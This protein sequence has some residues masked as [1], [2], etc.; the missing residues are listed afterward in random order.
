MK[1]TIMRLFPAIILLAI[2]SSAVLDNSSLA[3]GTRS[4]A[5][6]ASSAKVTG[7]AG[8]RSCHEKFYQLWSTSFHGLAMRP[9]SDAFAKEQLP[10]DPS[11]VPVGQAI[12][13][14]ETGPGQG[15]VKETRGGHVQKYRI[16]YVLGG[17]NVFYF[18]TLLDKGRLQTLP[19]AYDVRKR[20]WFDMA[21]SGVR[22][23]A[24]AAS[25]ALDWKDWPYTF[26]TGCHGCH[27]SQLS[28][29]YDQATGTYH[30][31]WVEPGINCET[32]HGPGKEHVVVCQAAPKGSPPKDLKLIRG[33]RSFT[34]EQ[35]N[36][37]CSTC[38]A[39]AVPI[40]PG[41]KPGDRFFDHFDLVTY[42]NPDYYSD[43]R[44]LGENYTYT[45]WSRSPCVKSGKLDCLHCHTSSGRY[46][47]TDPAHANDACLPCHA[48][49]VAEAAEHS[50]HPAG[51][52]GS[53]CIS[54]HMQKTEFARMSRSDH[55]MLPPTPR[56]TMSYGSPNACNTCHADK[57]PAWAD[58]HV[59]AWHE[60]DYQAPILNQAALVEAARKRDW[61][62]LPRM[63][64]YLGEDGADPIVAASLL[65][66]LRNC[67]DPGK[68][69]AIVKAATSPSPL[70]RAAAAETLA[71][72]AS[73]Q[74]R[75]A[76][77]RLTADDFRLVRIRAAASLSGQPQDALKLSEAEANNVQIATKEY[78]DSLSARPDVWT[79][80][81]NLGNYYMSQGDFKRAV[82]C[83]EAAWKMDPA[84]LPPRVNA[85]IAYSRMGERAKAES[86]LQEAL[87][88]SPEDATANFNMGLLKAEQGNMAE[89]EKHLRAALKS[90]PAMAE[91]AYNL[92]V[93]LA[94]DNPQQAVDYCRQAAELRPDAPKY[95][96]TWAF[97]QAQTG[98][99]AGAV[100]VLTN[101]LRR[102][103]NYRDAARLLAKIER[104]KP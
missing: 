63:L 40:T 50:H 79:S 11:D 69:E 29:N 73:R 23:F 58:W 95:A 32:C 9:Y 34:P 53:R 60:N 30:T 62:R 2:L 57:E 44:D 6:A 33:G 56:A 85:S 89:A 4:A 97:F 41:F 38:H 102:Y 93:L 104:M 65:R 68:E 101:L 24:N 81:Y 54:C 61:N 94:R 25:Q 70:V 39:K 37:Q 67:P 35:N 76:L 22:H 48:S 46:R 15:W 72:T 103:P 5:P 1:A 14:A 91:A 100:T 12:Y 19:V 88:Q 31:T 10:K 17:K 8:C 36:A 96:Y 59:R 66:L 43:G 74:A 55:S 26:N 84:S 87:K 28:T 80:P 64:A 3:Q 71:G 90:D 75:D 78:L 98:D 16:A 42:E 13:R 45:S 7:S 82:T 49:R 21:A 92:G 27:V 47:F 83:F 20:E 99:Q 51:S 18:L 77:V 86:A 52:P